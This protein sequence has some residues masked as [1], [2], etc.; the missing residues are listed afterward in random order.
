MKSLVTRTLSGG[1]YAVVMVAGMII[2]PLLFAV[3][4][5]LVTIFTLL[6]FYQ[7]ATLAGGE[8]HKCGGAVTALIFFGVVFA[9]A[10]GYLP[11]QSLGILPLLPLLLLI[12][13]LYRKKKNPLANMAYTLAGFL[14]VVIP[15]SLGSLLIFPRMEETHLFYPWILVGGVVTI[16]LFDSGAYLIGTAFGKHRLF[17]RISPKKSWEG[18]IGG[19]ITALLTGMVNTRLFPVLEGT[20]WMVIS[21][22]VILFGTW[23]DLVESMMKRSLGIKDSGNILP[24]HGGF[25]DRFDSYL[26]VVPVVVMWLWIT[27]VLT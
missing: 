5:G 27:G 25:L 23:G 6:E 4:F 2:H 8:P 14:Y 11:L 3:V 19:G 20:Q 9:Y 17:E 15:M 7:L 26:M 18:V 1:I 16:W 12:T 21:L 10:A 24:G 13:E 22:I